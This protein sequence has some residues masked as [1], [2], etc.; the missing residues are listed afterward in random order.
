MTPLQATMRLAELQ[1]R[2]AAEDAHKA[3]LQV[4]WPTVDEQGWHTLPD[5]IRATIAEA[6]LKTC[7]TGA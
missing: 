4:R 5:Q 3:D 7:H 2:I 1:A 6:H